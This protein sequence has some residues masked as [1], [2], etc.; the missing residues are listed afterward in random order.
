MRNCAHVYPWKVTGIADKGD[1]LYEAACHALPDYRPTAV[2]ISPTPVVYAR[3]GFGGKE[4]WKYLTDTVRQLQHF[5]QGLYYNLD[6]WSQYSRY[7]DREKTFIKGQRDYIYDAQCRYRDIEAGEQKTTLPMEPFVQCGFETPAILMMSL[8]ESA[9]QSTDGLIR[10]FPVEDLFGNCGF[11]LKA[12]GGFLVSALL[13][14]G[15]AVPALRIVSKKGN[16]CLV[17]LEKLGG[18]A[19]LFEVEGTLQEKEDIDR[20][21]KKDRIRKVGDFQKIAE[22]STVPGG[23]YLILGKKTEQTEELC[24]L[25]NFA[26]PKR[27]NRN[28]KRY[29]E[30]SIGRENQFGRKIVD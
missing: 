6:H 13:R 17:D 10:P 12:R 1:R 29:H 19:W 18:E 15:K 5:P 11:I 25:G 30:A 23:E 28:Y 21:K 9:M 8:H 3:L 27:P 20:E 7:F 24:L 26:L 14:N 16:K 22:F 4:I 2:A